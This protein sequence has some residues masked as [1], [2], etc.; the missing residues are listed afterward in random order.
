MCWVESG[1]KLFKKRWTHRLV[2]KRGHQ[3]ALDTSCALTYLNIKKIYDDVYTC[4][5]ECGVARKLDQPNNEFAGELK[6]RYELTHP[7]IC[8]LVDEVGCNISQKG[9]GHVTESK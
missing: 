4:T 7:E 5:C 1:G 3:F 8:L 2:T 6:T 9:D